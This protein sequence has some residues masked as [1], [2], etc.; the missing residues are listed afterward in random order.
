MG[1]AGSIFMTTG[2]GRPAAESCREILVG[3]PRFRTAARRAGHWLRQRLG[4]PGAAMSSASLFAPRFQ[5]F[6]PNHS[7]CVDFK[8]LMDAMRT[9][10]LATYDL[11]SARAA[12]MAQFLRWWSRNSTR[13]ASCA[14]AQAWPVGMGAR[15]LVAGT[16]RNAPDWATIARPATEQGRSPR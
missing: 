14:F 6:V 16:R 10:G 13:A 2:F 4:Y 3:Q 9:C 8:R 7:Q 11:R 12:N 1:A 15:G 5:I